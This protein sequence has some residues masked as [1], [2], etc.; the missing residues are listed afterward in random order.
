MQQ[1]RN[2]STVSQLLTQLQA[3]QN[4]VNS[5]SD[6]REFFT[7]L[8]QRAALERPTFPGNPFLFRVKGPC[9]S[10]I[11]ECRMI[12]EMLWVLQETFLNDL[13]PEKDEPLLSSTIQSLTDSMSCA[14]AFERRRACFFFYCWYRYAS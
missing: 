7:I 1:H 4:K 10:A 9:L 13:L 3:L 11:L 5:L 2:S 8:K 6:A 12:H 14:L